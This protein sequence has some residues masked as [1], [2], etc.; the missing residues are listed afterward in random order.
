MCEK[1]VA[2]YAR[3]GGRKSGV[4]TGVRCRVIRILKRSACGDLVFDQLGGEVIK[5]E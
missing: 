1:A 4:I 2:K 5:V 3:G